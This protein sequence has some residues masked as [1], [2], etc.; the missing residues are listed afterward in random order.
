M[1]NTSFENLE[2]WKRSTELGVEVYRLSD[3]DELGDDRV[4]PY[5]VR[6][7]VISI[8]SNIA[9]GAASGSPL[10]YHR[11]LNHSLG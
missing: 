6:K 1:N 3:S 11:F 4:L 8:P 9:E 5:R 2:V 10:N 7:P